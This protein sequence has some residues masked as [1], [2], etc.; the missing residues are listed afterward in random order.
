MVFTVLKNGGSFHGKLLVI[1]RWCLM[2]LMIH[3]NLAAKSRY[4]CGGVRGF[5]DIL[6]Y[7]I[8]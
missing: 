5:L 7:I 4:C 6:C 1:T 2:D 8:V 3:G